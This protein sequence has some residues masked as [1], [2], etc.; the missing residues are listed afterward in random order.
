V[1]TRHFPKLIARRM[2]QGAGHFLPAKSHRPC[3]HALLEVLQ[4]PHNEKT[5]S[6]NGRMLAI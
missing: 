2:I 3:L 5:Q 4:Y 1:P 6:Y